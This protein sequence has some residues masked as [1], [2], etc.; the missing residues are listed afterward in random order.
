MGADRSGPTW[1][2]LCGGKSGDGDGRE[3]ESCHGMLGDK[4]S[5]DDRGRT[6]CW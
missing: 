6:H 5:E 1:G 2:E 3:V 4:V